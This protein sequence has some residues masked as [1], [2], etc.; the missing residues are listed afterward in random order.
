[1][2]HRAHGERDT[3][4]IG[5]L[6]NWDQ[7][8]IE[9]LRKVGEAVKKHGKIFGIAGLYTRTDILDK[10]VDDFG[11]RWIIGAN[12]TGLLFG[13]AKANHALIRSIQK[14]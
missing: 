10:V 14:A 13:A 7:D 5:T 3:F 11:A 12:G 8:F 2:Y 1:M 9:A 4:Q 6:G